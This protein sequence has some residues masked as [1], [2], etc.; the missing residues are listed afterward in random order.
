MGTIP[1]DQLG[2][3]VSLISDHPVTQTDILRQNLP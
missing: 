1:A 3:E 2:A